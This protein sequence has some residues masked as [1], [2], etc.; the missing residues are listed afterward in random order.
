MYNPQALS[1]PGP[2]NQKGRFLSQVHRQPLFFCSAPSWLSPASQEEDHRPLDEAFC[3]LPPQA[4]DQQV[5]NLQMSSWFVG[6]WRR[7]G[8]LRSC[9]TPRPSL[10]KWTSLL[11]GSFQLISGDF[12]RVAHLSSGLMHVPVIRCVDPLPEAEKEWLF[13]V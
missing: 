12:E 4:T 13:F 6:K 5:P 2:P 8:A 3:R 7:R 10:R 9:P 11:Y 1:P